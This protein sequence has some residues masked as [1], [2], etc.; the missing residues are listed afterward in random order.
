MGFTRCIVPEGNALRDDVP[1]TIELLGV[2][3]VNE[4]LDNLIDW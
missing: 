2:R 4:A 3:T 1:G